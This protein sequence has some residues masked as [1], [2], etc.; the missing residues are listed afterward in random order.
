MIYIEYTDK[1]TWPLY[2]PTKDYKEKIELF[3]QTTVSDLGLPIEMEPLLI[4]KIYEALFRH[5]IESVQEQ[6]HGPTTTNK[7]EENMDIQQDIDIKNEPFSTSTTIPATTPTSL[8]KTEDK[9]SI[10]TNEFPSVKLVNQNNFMNVITDS[11]KQN[12]PSNIETVTTI[13][14]ALLPE[15]KYT[16][17]HAWKS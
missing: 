13:P 7:N 17:A 16:N 10:A 11:W 6:I 12:K 15:N 5:L 8:S 4:F 3:A 9:I 14:H 1:I 2:C